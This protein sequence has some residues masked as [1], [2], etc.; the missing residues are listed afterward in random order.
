MPVS[1]RRRT[2]DFLIHEVDP[3][4]PDHSLVCPYFANRGRVKSEIMRHVWNAVQIGLK[5]DIRL[6]EGNAD[7]RKNHSHVMYRIR[8]IIILAHLQNCMHFSFYHKSIQFLVILAGKLRR[9]SILSSPTDLILEYNLCIV[10][11]LCTVVN[12]SLCGYA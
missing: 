9:N 6:Y 8:S 1:L 2:N 7:P 12:L 4:L 11:L 10:Y 3:I 5:E